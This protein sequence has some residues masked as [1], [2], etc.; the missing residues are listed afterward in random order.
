MID[1]ARRKY[2]VFVDEQHRR[3]SGIW[4]QHIANRMVHQHKPENEWTVSLL[5]VQPTDHVLEIGF[6]PGFAIALLAPLMPAGHIAGIDYSRKMIALASRRNRE[7][8]QS[9]RVALHYGEATAF[10]FV[11]ESFD[12]ALSIHTLY[13]W[14]DPVEVLR[15]IWRVLRPGGPFV[16][17][18]LPKDRWPRGDLAATISGVY[19]GEE[20]VCLMQ[21]AGFVHAHIERG[22]EPKPFRE[23]AVIGVK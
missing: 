11:S 22:P 21:D 9:G 1:L 18:F 6:G 17:T 3:P 20:V 19:S 14:C 5:N 13:F 4:G 15:D 23:L 8:I 12:K 16:L 10:P 7:A 2:R